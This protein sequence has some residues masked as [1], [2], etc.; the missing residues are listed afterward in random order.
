LSKAIHI[1]DEVIEYH[2]D[3]LLRSEEL[4][5]GNQ[6]FV[7]RFTHG[8]LERLIPLSE[9]SENQLMLVLSQGER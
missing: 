5:P 7:A 6:D 1:G 9:Y 2:G 4:G 8:T 3:I